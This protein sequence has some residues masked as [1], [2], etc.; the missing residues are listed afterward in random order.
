MKLHLNTADGQYMVTAY[1]PDHIQVNGA[2]FGRSLILFPNRVLPDWPVP[3]FEQ[4]LAEHF[5]PLLEHQPEIVLLGTGSRHRFPHPSLYAALL[6]AG[7][8]VEVMNTGAACRTY[9]IL[10]AEGRRAAAALIIET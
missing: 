4:L 3:A 2:R 1:E 7:I 8:G 9:N 5:L 10:V 6:Q